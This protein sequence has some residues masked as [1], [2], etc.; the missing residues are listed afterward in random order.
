MDVNDLLRLEKITKD[1][2]DDYVIFEM[3]DLGRAKLQKW[4]KRYILTEDHTAGNF[5][6]TGFAFFFGRISFIQDI[7]RNIELVKIKLKEQDN[8]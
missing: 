4:I 6:G 8:V 5:R 7:C 1:E 3:T 2:Y